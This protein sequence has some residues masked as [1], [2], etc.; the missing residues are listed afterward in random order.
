MK[1]TVKWN[2]SAVCLLLAATTASASTSYSGPGED[3]SPAGQATALYQK[4]LRETSKGDKLTTKALTDAA[5]AD[6]ARQAFDRA[7]ENLAA[8]VQ[9][10]P[11]HAE[12]YE[13]AGQIYLRL[14]QHDQ[15]L[16]TCRQ[17]SGINERL[18]DA[19]VC[20]VRALL[21]LGQSGEAQSVVV[22]L[23]QSSPKLAK[24]VRA[25]LEKWAKSAPESS[26]STDLTALLGA[27]QR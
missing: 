10:Y 21:A 22:A 9:V 4:A 3:A 24:Q 13:L 19:R 20:E 6:K 26:G 5:Q 15:A 14:G 7:L 16:R 23:D 12:S 25:S 2:V 1:S 17:A 27:A 18:Q 11:L 8:A